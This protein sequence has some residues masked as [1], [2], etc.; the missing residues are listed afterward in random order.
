[1]GFILDASIDRFQYVRGTYPAVRDVNLKVREGEFVVIT[2]PAGAG[3]TT[4]C[5]CLTGVIPHFVSGDYQ[6]LVRV[7]GR[8]ITELRLPEIAGLVGLVLQRPENQLF[9]LTVEEDVAFGPENLCMDADDIRSRVDRSLAFVGMRNFGRRMCGALSGGETQRIVLSCILAM[10]PDLF[11]LDQPAA[12]LDP[13]GRKQIYENI[14]RLNRDEGKTI[15]L[16]EDRLGDVLPYASRMVLLHE[17]RIVRDAPP[18]E[19]FADEDI[20]SYGIRVPDGVRLHHSLKKRRLAPERV[21]LTPQDIAGH[22]KP[23]VRPGRAFSESVDPAACGVYLT[24]CPLARGES[25]WRPL[26]ARRG[27]RR[28]VALGRHGPAQ[29]AQATRLWRDTLRARLV[30]QRRTRLWRAVARGGRRPEVRSTAVGKATKAPCTSWLTTLKW[31]WCPANVEGASDRAGESSQST[32][33]NSA[34]CVV[35]VRA[36]SFRYPGAERWALEDVNLDFKRGEL[37]AIIGGNG[38]GKTT[39]A[40]HFIGLLRPAQGKVIVKG[41]DIGRVPTARISNTVGYLFQDP[42]F[43]IFCNSIFDEVAFGL[44]TRKVPPDQIETLANETLRKVG[45]FALRERHPYLLS[46]GQRQRLALASIL[47][48][49][50][51]VLVIDE[52]S[53]GLDYRETLE[54]MDLLAEFRDRGGTVIMITHDIEMVVRYAQRSIVMAGGRVLLDTPTTDIGKYSDVLMRAGIQLPQFYHFAQALGLPPTCRDIEEVVRLLVED[55][56]QVH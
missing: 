46:R 8:N 3:K 2:G 37:A 14:C 42:D 16:I 31:P 9:N 13:L 28:S 55:C 22:L 54:I 11:V 18:E 32:C 12:E 52:P 25:P 5:H 36:L 48:H 49:G 26:R 6:G 43:Q 1:M 29:V 24:P 21:C 53:T 34:P 41:Q 47:A 50:P 30:Y 35:Q 51:E 15:I 17:G 40:K 44:K 23:L 20:L 38:A 27:R 56:R 4:L 33:G 7:K 19:F 45:L 10:D 39:L